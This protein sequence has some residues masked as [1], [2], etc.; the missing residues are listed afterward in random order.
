MKSDS[1]P[2]SGFT[3][4][5]RLSLE[6]EFQHI[7]RQK[8]DQSAIAPILNKTFLQNRS[9]KTV[10]QQMSRDL[11]DF[12]TGQSA[13]SIRAQQQPTGE[14]NWIVYDPSTSTRST[15]LS[16]SEMRIWLENRHR[17]SAI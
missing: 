7:V 6:T 14:L 2:N 15:F 3:P 5:D 10:L 8:R 11:I 16:E 9:L 12:L 1:I 13:M 4:G 17:E